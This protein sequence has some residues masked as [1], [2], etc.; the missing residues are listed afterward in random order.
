MASGRTKVAGAIAVGYLLG[1]THKMGLTLGVSAWLLAKNVNAEELIRRLATSQ[2]ARSL[3][4]GPITA[5]ADRLADALNQRTVVLE[6]APAGAG[7]AEQAAP[8][9]E[10]A[11]GE[12]SQN[13]AQQST[14]PGQ[15]GEG[16]Q[17]E[18]AAAKSEQGGRRPNRSEPPGRQDED[19]RRSQATAR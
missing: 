6:Q 7:A 2:I 5:R 4:T 19:T 3:V 16:N 12:E 17:G 13:E 14:Q 18:A 1:R 10:A 9:A 11:R 15:P 8:Q